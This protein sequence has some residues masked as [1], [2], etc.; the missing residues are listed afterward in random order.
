MPEHLVMF[1]QKAR[2]E[3]ISSNRGYTNL[4]IIIEHIEHDI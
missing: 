3:L 4:I 1:C 2:F